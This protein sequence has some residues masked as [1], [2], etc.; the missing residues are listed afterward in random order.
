MKVDRDPVPFVPVVITLESPGEL[1]HLHHILSWV[2]VNCEWM[3]AGQWPDMIKLRQI[4]ERH[5]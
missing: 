3:T 5:L 1:D 2:M 4:L